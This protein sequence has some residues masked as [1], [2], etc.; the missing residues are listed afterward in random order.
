MA[1]TS[2]SSAPVIDDQAQTQVARD[3]VHL[4]RQLGHPAMLSRSATST[5]PR[6]AV[7]VPKI[8]VGSLCSTLRCQATGAVLPPGLVH[9]H[10]FER[11][12]GQRRKRVGDPEDLMRSIRTSTAVDSSPKG[13]SNALG[14]QSRIPSC[15]KRSSCHVD[16]QRSVVATSIPVAPL[17]HLRARQSLH[18][19]GGNE[20]EVDMPGL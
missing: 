1:T 9:G 18:P 4:R 8:S 17:E 20:T 11:A 7:P 19:A 5:A 15:S 13:A 6:A 12:S 3:T 2:V 10:D 14:G 16:N